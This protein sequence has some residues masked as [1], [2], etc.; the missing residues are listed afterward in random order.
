MFVATASARGTANS[1]A[2]TKVIFLPFINAGPDWTTGFDATGFFGFGNHALRVDRV[3]FG[4]AMII[5]GVCVGG[6]MW[7][8]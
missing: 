1:S 2:A 5:P 7:E 8:E 4:V 3:G 6:V